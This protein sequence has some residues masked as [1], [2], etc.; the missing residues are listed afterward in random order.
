MPHYE[1]AIIIRDDLELTP[2]EA[3]SHGIKATTRAKEAATKTENKHW[4]PS[5]EKT[6]LKALNNEQIQEVIKAATEA[7]IPIAE[8]ETELG[9][10]AAI[11]IGPTNSKHL[12]T[13]TNHLHRY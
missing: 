11:A 2:G 8:S 9:K 12:H 6:V 13:L 10:N 5:N 7:D 3:I 4:S 1:Q